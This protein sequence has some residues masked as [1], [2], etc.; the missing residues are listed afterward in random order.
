MKRSILGILTVISLGINGQVVN[1]KDIEGVVIQS[2]KINY[3]NKKE[4]PAYAVLKKV[5]DKNYKNAFNSYENYKY[6]EYQKIE[7]SFNRTCLMFPN[8]NTTECEQMKIPPM[9]FFSFISY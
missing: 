5:W 2:K 9:F 1:T 3:T 7:A 6:E 8:Q 4:N